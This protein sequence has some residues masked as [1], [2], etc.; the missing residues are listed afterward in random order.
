MK[1]SETDYHEEA[2]RSVELPDDFL[3]QV[4]KPSRYLGNEVNAEVKSP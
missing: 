3:M 2:T 1:I 4:Q